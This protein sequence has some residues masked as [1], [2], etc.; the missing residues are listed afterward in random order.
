MPEGSRVARLGPRRVSGMEGWTRTRPSADRTK[1]DCRR[2][3]I[4]R[5]PVQPIGLAFQLPSA[6]SCHCPR[7]AAERSRS[8]PT[9]RFPP[10]CKHRDPIPPAHGRAPARRCRALPFSDSQE[11]ASSVSYWQPTPHRA[12]RRRRTV[13]RDSWS[14]L[15]WVA[16]TTKS[17]AP[18]VN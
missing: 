7:G 12:T 10:A 17:A 2:G 11:R 4:M 13:C 18:G 5:A 8:S 15:C 14:P 6:S 3:P 1:R 9:G 16:I